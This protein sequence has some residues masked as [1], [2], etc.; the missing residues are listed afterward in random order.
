[1]PNS[2]PT[3]SIQREWITIWMILRS[4]LMKSWVM[5]TGWLKAKFLLSEIKVS[6][7]H[8]GPLAQLESSNLGLYSIDKSLNFPPSNW[9]IVLVIMVT[10]AAME[11]TISKPSTMLETSASPPR[12]NTPMKCK[13]KNASTKRAH[14]KSTA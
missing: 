14:S 1:M 13:Q 4:I 5:S 11:D 12:N 10:K 3:I 6:V 2:E 9:L 8:V 7:D